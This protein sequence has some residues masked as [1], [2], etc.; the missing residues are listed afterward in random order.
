MVILLVLN[1]RT[2][3]TKRLNIR[4]EEQE[5]S[6]KKRETNKLKPDIQITL[7]R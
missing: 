4:T 1:M 2:E 6:N 7:D 3:E 5:T